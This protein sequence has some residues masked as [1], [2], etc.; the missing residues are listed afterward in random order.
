MNL[1]RL[2][3]H[4]AEGVNVVINEGG[5]VIEDNKD[6]E[7]DDMADNEKDARARRDS[8]TPDSHDVNVE[9]E[10]NSI[11]MCKEVQYYWYVGRVGRRMRNTEAQGKRKGTAAPEAL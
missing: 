5:D 8:E 1:Q 11:A 6:E 3:R 10:G 7:V 2:L 9:A 4:V